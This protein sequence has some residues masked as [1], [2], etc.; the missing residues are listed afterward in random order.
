MHPGTITECEEP[1]G[2]GMQVDVGYLNVRQCA[3]HQD[4]ASRRR[5]AKQEPTRSHAAK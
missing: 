3:G 2:E 1:S 4:L 5:A